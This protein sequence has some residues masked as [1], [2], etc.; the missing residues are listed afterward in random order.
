MQ[1]EPVTG[2]SHQLRLHMQSIGH[3]ILGDPFYANLAQQ[4][5]SSRLLL[6]AAV[7]EFT[8]PQSGELMSFSAEAD[9]LQALR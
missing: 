2:R 6:H 7:L 5:Q 1:L 9:F 4:Q 3:A 8:H